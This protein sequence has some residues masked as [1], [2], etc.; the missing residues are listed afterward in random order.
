MDTNRHEAIDDLYN[1][2]ASYTCV[3][4]RTSGG[5]CARDD[6]AQK[7]TATLCGRDL[8]TLDAGTLL[9]YY[10]LAVDHIGSSEDLRHFL[11]R[12]LELLV[13]DPGGYLAP[14]LLPNVIERAHPAGMTLAQRTALGKFLVAATGT[15]PSRILE[16]S[17]EALQRSTQDS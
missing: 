3:E 1:E 14:P 5:D 2:F 17:M 11:P 4:L 13:D 12:I 10:Y 7:L 16:E 9:D 8:R 15:L 6:L